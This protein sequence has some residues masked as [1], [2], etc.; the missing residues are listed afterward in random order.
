M[1]IKRNR[2]LLAI[3]IYKIFTASLLAVTSIA[4]L[5]ALKNHDKLAE[6]SS[7][8][9][10]ES[11]LP[12]VEFFLHTLININPKTL[13]LSDIGFAIYAVVNAIEAIGL[14]YEQRWAIIFVLVIVGMTIPVEIFE[15]IQG[16]T[17]LKLVILILNVTVFIY[18]LRHF[19]ESQKIPKGK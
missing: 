9:L 3:I 19:W 17:P 15:L 11:K 1:K 2:A 16:I 5:L 6:F 12:L 14:W 10:L 18:L 13:K 7:S 8:Y 4:L